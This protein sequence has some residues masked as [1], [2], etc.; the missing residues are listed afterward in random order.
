LIKSNLFAVIVPVLLSPLLLLM[1]SYTTGLDYD[2]LS[3]A[4]AQTSAPTDTFEMDG[5]IGSLILGMPP[6]TKTVDMITVP[7]FILSGDW[8]MHVSQGNL[9]DFSATFYT[10]P[11]NGAE[12]HTHQ[13]SNFRVNDN[14]PIQLSPDT[15]VS[16]SGLMDVGTNG[17][18]AWDNVNATVDISKGRSI[19]IALADEDT[20]R[21]FM[22]QEIY[23]IVHKLKV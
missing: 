5:Q 1:P 13:L 23:G 7:K 16:L 8:S 2:I 18:T 14:A 15:S 19:A 10:G 3:T 12:N 9:K 22:G 17:N 21:H 11:V 6:N 4:L 20:Q